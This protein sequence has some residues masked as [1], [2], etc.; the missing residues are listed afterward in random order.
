MALFL[1]FL[2][3]EVSTS[4]FGSRL[5]NLAKANPGSS[6]QIAPVVNVPDMQVN[7]TISLVESGLWVKVDAT[8]TMR[9]LHAYGDQFLT[10]NYGMG[11]VPNP[12]EY[13][14]VT[15]AYDMLDAYYPMPLNAT[16]I[17]FKMDDSELNWTTR[18]QGFHLFDTNLPEVEWRIQHVPRN[19]IIT[20]HYEF[21]V[22]TTGETYGYLG[23]YALLFPL[24][25][26]FDLK[27]IIDYGF[28][29]YPWFGESTTHFSIQIDNAFPNTSAF[30]IDGFGKLSRLRPPL[31]G[32]MEWQE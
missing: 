29:G 17:S 26:R 14:T 22:Q 30:S 15:V 8:Y 16:N 24:G 25:A 18:E 6:N 32:R 19:F 23:E 13:V 4:V 21:P 11:L 31:Q 2:A 5:I 20:A 10:P 27:D 12:S 3:P 1:L 7:A 9:T 28:T